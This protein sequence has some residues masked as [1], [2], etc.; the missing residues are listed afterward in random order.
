MTLALAFAALTVP[1]AVAG[2]MLAQDAAKAQTGKGINKG[3]SR[4]PLHVLFDAAIRRAREGYNPA[5]F[6]VDRLY[7]AA[8]SRHPSRREAD[9]ISAH[10]NR[11]A[12]TIAVLQDIFW[13]LLN[14][15]EFVLNR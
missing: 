10:L 12:D 2:W 13:A 14:S 6:M 15:N 8:L 7:I 1:G 3:S 11:D 5:G 4:L 9:V